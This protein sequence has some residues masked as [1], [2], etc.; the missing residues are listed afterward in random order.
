[1]SGPAIKWAARQKLRS[2]VA[3]RVLLA[4]AGYANRNGEAWPSQA[5]LAAQTGFS[6]RSIEYALKALAAWGLITR[7]KRGSNKNR[8][9]RSSD[10]VTL[11]IGTCHGSD[12]PLP[13][14]SIYSQVSAAKSA[15]SYSQDSAT[16][17]EGELVADVCEGLRSITYSRPERGPARGTTFP[18]TCA[19]I[20]SEI[21]K[22]QGG[23]FADAQAPPTRYLGNPRK[24]L[25]AQATPAWHSRDGSA[26]ARTTGGAQ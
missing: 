2:G 22:P 9:G 24:G 12:R 3:Y 23:H 10:L 18:S 6:K 11:A 20:S 4:L 25:A 14:G 8:G 1:M 7:K 13:E 15:Q 5:T 21:R 17:W 19:Q 16:K 26:P